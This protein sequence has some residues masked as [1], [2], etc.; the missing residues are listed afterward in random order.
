MEQL[1]ILHRRPGES[2]KER[3]RLWKTLDAADRN[4]AIADA[5]ANGKSTIPFGRALC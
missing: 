3:S 4:D 1:L 5:K 2:A